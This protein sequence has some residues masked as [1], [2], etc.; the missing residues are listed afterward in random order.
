MID[1]L[2]SRCSVDITVSI[3]VLSA[4]GITGV[5]CEG[6]VLG[7]PRPV[8]QVEE[9]AEVCTKVKHRQGLGDGVT[10]YNTTIFRNEGES[11]VINIPMN[12]CGMCACSNPP[13]CAC[14]LIEALLT[15]GLSVAWLSLTVLIVPGIHLANDL[16][17]HTLTSLQHGPC[18][19]ALSMEKVFAVGSSLRGREKLRPAEGRQE[20]GKACWG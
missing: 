16:L 4:L 3:S 9:V 2:K 14:V 19:T 6:R 17:L 15:M 5:L 7:E 1:L 8:H 18:D 10:F 12:G 11:E 13:L 20:R